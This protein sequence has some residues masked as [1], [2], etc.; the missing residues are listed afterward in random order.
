MKIAVCFSGQPRTWMKCV[1]TWN[2]LFSSLQ[3]RHNADIDVFFH[4]WKNNAPSHGTIAN[5]KEDYFNKIGSPII[6]AELEE[7]VQKLKP[8]DYLFEDGNVSALKIQEVLNLNSRHN[9]I[10]GNATLS[11][12]APQFYSVMRSAHLKKKYEFA[13]NIR[14]DVCIRFRFD[15]YFNESQIDYFSR[16]DFRIPKT[17]TVYPCHTSVD[18]SCFPFFRFGDIL[19]FSDSVSFDRICDFYRWLP[20]IGKKSF[21]NNDIVSTEHALYFYSKML[22]M[23]VSP[24]SVDPKIYRPENYLEQKIAGGLPGTLGNHELI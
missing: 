6:A 10:Y 16:C 22:R 11:W 5:N 14:Y 15:L 7:L 13:N 24:I 4:A 3:D 21:P 17:N 20:I 2:S 19:W 18:E 9:L 23:N 8:K 1:D 12:A